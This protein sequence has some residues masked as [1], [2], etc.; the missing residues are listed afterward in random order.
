MS[1]I[2]QCGVASSIGSLLRACDVYH[3]SM[4]NLYTTSPA[5]VFPSCGTR[6]CWF[7]HLLGSLW[8][9]PT[10]YCDLS[11]SQHLIISFIRTLPY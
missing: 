6:Y 3:Y 8:K 1:I 7:S 5:P 11:D 2:C 4:H 9:I 10:L